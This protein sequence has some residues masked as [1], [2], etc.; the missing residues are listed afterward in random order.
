MIRILI[1]EDDIEIAYLERDYLEMQGYQVDLVHDGSLVEE[2]IKK[3][4][5][6]LLLL[7]VMLPNKTG[8]DLCRDLR[9]KVDFPILM[10]TSKQETVD[11]VRGLGLGADD[12]I[13]KPF[14]PMELVARVK[15][16]LMRYQRF[17]KG[18]DSSELTIRNMIIFLENWKVTLDGQEIKLPNR[19]FELLVYLAKHPNRV[20]SKE[21]LFEKIWGY[22]YVGDSATV[23]VHI[24]RLRDKL[25]S[26]LIE[27]VWGAGYRLND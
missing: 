16:H 23:A 27:T 14:D 13:S 12:Y 8:Y 4:E 1:A 6:S 20:F 24:N 18:S 19:E 3:E 10:V 5:Y 21:H 11:I 25:G 2:Q 17:Q 7:D 26:E 15:A 9:D 22:D